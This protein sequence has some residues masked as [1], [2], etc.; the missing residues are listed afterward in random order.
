MPQFRHQVLH[1]LMTDTD[2][3]ANCYLAWLSVTA[4]VVEAQPAK[5]SVRQYDC[6]YLAS[7][8]AKAR[9]F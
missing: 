3:R 6:E 8:F 1:S 7:A 5:D 2:D 4:G 9:P